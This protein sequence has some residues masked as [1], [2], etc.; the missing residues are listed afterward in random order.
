[1][2]TVTAAPVTTTRDILAEAQRLAA[3]MSPSGARCATASPSGFTDGDAGSNW[4][5]D[6]EKA[7]ERCAAKPCTTIQFATAR[8]SSQTGDSLTCTSKRMTC[9]EWYDG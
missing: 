3:Q 7:N 4:Y 9:K 1:M 8:S 6:P 5:L 2:G